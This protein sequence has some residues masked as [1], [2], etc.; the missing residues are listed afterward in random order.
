MFLAEMVT[1]WLVYPA[2]RKENVYLSTLAN[3]TINLF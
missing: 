3:D 1:E 2:A